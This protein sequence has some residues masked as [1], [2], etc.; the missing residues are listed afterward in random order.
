MVEAIGNGVRIYGGQLA[1]AGGRT[2]QSLVHPD[3]L[4]VALYESP[5]YAFTV[6]PLDVARL[7]IN[8]SPSRVVG[9]V[10]GDTSR[11]YVARRHSLFLTPA[12][13]SATW[14]KASSSRH[15][16]I[17]FNPRAFDHPDG[18]AWGG[19][20]A[21]AVPL[22]NVNLA[23]AGAL[24][25]LLAAELADRQAFGAEAIDSLARLILARVARRQVCGGPTRSNPLTPALLA[26]LTDYI[27]DRLDQRLLV[28]ELAAVVGLSPNR[29]AQ[30]FTSA[31]RS[32]PHQFV[33]QLRLERAVHL[34]HHS[35]HTLAD[36]AAACGFASQ[37]HMTQLM[38]RRLGT[39][40]ARQRSSAQPFTSSPATRSPEK[41]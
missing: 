20:L 23:G 11:T 38:R 9:H 34:L 21:D 12:G 26:R 3:A 35:T 18:E 7:S 6:P 24:F 30:A 32:P 8:L 19:L 40:P 17:Y 41:S 10:E 39:T 15:I 29:F 27:T 16:N 22:L 28:P 1:R 5:A 37:Q 36:I 33:L 4:A 31:T 13:A 25:D 14:H 2:T